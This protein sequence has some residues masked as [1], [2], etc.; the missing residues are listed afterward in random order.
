MRNLTERAAYLQGLAE[1]L[2]LGVDSKEG[3]VFNGMIGLINDLARTVDDLQKAHGELESYIE[4]LDE[5]LN[6]LEDE[7]YDDDID[8]VEMKTDG[9]GEEYIDVECPECHE[10]VCFEPEILEDDDVI[11][12]TCP[13]CDTVV[14]VN[15]ETLED[16]TTHTEDI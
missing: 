11:E 5:D 16:T 2:D 7:V 8:A 9:C 12:V 10:T 15:D 13:N 4:T 6:D 3:K 14:F 1:G